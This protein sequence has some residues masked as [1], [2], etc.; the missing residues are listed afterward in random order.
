[1]RQTQRAVHEAQADTN[2]G[3]QV[4][5]KGTYTDMMMR[6]PEFLCAHRAKLPTEKIFKQS[7]KFT[8]LQM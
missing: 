2:T 6:K 7:K 1:M 5:E 4:K 3:E 8:N